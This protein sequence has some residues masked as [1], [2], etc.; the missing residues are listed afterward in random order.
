MNLGRGLCVRF[1]DRVQVRS[2]AAWVCRCCLGDGV[3]MRD[4]R[5]IGCRCGVGGCTTVSIIVL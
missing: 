4:V 2:I 5:V 3:Q 1:E